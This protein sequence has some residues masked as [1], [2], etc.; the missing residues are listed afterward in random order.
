MVFLLLLVHAVSQGDDAYRQFWSWSA[1]PPVLLLNLTSLFFVPS[2]PSPGSELA[3]QAMVVHMGG[4]RLPGA[5]IAA[6]NY[7]LWVLSTALVVWMLL[8]E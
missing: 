3:P 2:T 8:G 5:F 1:S 6:S 7:A 4:K